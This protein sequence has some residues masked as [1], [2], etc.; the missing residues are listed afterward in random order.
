MYEAIDY[1]TVRQWFESQTV[2]VKLSLSLQKEGLKS[3][4]AMLNSE[5]GRGRVVFGV[6][7]D[8][9]VAGLQD[10]PDFDGAQR[11]ISQR[12]AQLFDPQPS[13]DI[14]VFAVGDKHILV[15]DAARPTAVPLYEFDGRAYRRQGSENLR[16]TQSERATLVRSRDRDQHHG[17][18]LCDACG[19]YVGLLQN[20][21]ITYGADGPTVRS[22]FRCPGCT[23]GQM[24]PA[25]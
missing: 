7:P 1:G 8:G 16:L 2:E 10:G 3:L 12:I 17:P 24:W 4:C 15:L 18:W 9:A 22:S 25:R 21:V 20:D 5:V 23:D 11:K 6:G 14:Q 13:V 19:T